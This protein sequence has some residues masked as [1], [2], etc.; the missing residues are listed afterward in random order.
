MRSGWC[1]GIEL[2][3][4]PMNRL[5]RWAR[6]VPFLCHQTLTRTASEPDLSRHA[7]VDSG[8]GTTA[9]EFSRSTLG[10]AIFTLGT[11]WDWMTLN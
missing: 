9:Q 5:E 6:G 2:R 7:R 4:T 3:S 11:S 10:V 1:E 8:L